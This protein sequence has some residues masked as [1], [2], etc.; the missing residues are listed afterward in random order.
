MTQNA[1]N[2]SRKWFTVSWR[3]MHDRQTDRQTKFTLR[4]LERAR[5]RS[6]QLPV[7]SNSRTNNK[8]KGQ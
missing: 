5:S 8:C 7:R 2:K 4:P 3:S 6:P 1:Q